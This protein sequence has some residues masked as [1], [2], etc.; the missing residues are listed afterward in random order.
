MA[1]AIWDHLPDEAELLGRRVALGWRPR[2][3]PTKDGDVVLG[4]AACLPSPSGTPRPV[5]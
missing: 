3:T 1:V 2:T 5:A 4:Y